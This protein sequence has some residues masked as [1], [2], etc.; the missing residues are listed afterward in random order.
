MCGAIEERSFKEPAVSSDVGIRRA[1]KAAFYWPFVCGA[2][3]I[4]VYVLLRERVPWRVF[5]SATDIIMWANAVLA[6]AG[7]AFAGLRS[8]RRRER[9]V[10]ALAFTLWAFIAYFVVVAVYQGIAPGRW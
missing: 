1:E 7:S 4:S 9:I 2:L 10:A 8:A 3:T 6:A 5:Y